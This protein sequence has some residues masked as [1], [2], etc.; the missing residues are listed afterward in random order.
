MS[1]N[2][3]ELEREPDDLGGAFGFMAGA[4]VE[5]THTDAEGDWIT[6]TSY[7]VRLPHQC[8]YWKIVKSSDKKTA[9]LT[10]EA[11]IAEA[12]IALDKLREASA[13]GLERSDNKEGSP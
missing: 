5:A 2:F 12:N 1:K 7:V 11:F 9:V 8:D 10:M 3:W 6:E 4:N 13:E